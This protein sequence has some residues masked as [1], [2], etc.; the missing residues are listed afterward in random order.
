MA[1]P[2]VFLPLQLQRQKIPDWS[3]ACRSSSA[4]MAATIT[5]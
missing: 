1:L 2:V 5:I 3:T 4:T